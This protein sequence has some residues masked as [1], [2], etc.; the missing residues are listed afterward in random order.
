MVTALSCSAGPTEQRFPSIP[1][2]Y[3]LTL[4]G[5]RPMPV[6]LQDSPDRQ[7][8]VWYDSLNITNGQLRT[9][10]AYRYLDQIY[11]KITHV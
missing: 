8:S 5:T 9:S 1:G 10:Y 2:R 3:V 4:I 11:S 7:V 6:V